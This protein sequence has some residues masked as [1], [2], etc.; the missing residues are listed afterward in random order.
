LATSFKAG[1]GKMVANGNAAKQENVEELL[2]KLKLLHKEID[3]EETRFFRKKN[4]SWAETYQTLE[5]LRQNT[6]VRIS[7]IIG[8]SGLPLQEEATMR[9]YIHFAEGFI[10]II[11]LLFLLREDADKLRDGLSQV[12]S[13]IEK[14]KGTTKEI[15]D[16]KVK[17]DDV[18]KNFPALE[19][20]KRLENYSKFP[21]QVLIQQIQGSVQG[22]VLQEGMSQV[23]FNQQVTDAFKRA[24]LQVENNA[25]VSFKLRENV[26]KRLEILEQEL[27]SNKPDAGKIQNHWKW[28]RRNASW[29][30]PVITEVVIEGTKIA[31]G[32]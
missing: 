3:E 11:E 1:C 18:G 8:L 26:K 14:I 10:D 30:V 5:Y 6:F 21:I 12:T 13:E 27:K 7:E 2:E 17:L 24:Y 16:I 9:F 25:D 31:L 23:Y 32:R 19:I 4:P 28:L 22:N 29:V 15:E 20:I